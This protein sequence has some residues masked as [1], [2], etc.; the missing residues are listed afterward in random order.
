MI[1]LTS[2]HRRVLKILEGCPTGTTDFNLSFRFGVSMDCMLELTK[3]RL[4]T[5]REHR[6]AHS[7]GTQCWLCITPLGIKALEASKKELHDKVRDIITPAKT[8]QD[9][10]NSK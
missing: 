4:V 7:Q 10:L 5:I 2:D 3:A 6:L 8:V 9:F 1:L